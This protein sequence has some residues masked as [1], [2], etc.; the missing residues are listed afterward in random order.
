[1]IVKLLAGVEMA[2][3]DALSRLVAG[4]AASKDYCAKIK[5][6]HIQIIHRSWISTYKLTKKNTLIAQYAIRYVAHC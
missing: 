2:T 5:E 4:T 6:S 3:A 1:M